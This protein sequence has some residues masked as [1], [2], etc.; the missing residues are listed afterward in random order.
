MWKTEMH[1]LYSRCYDKTPV[2]G[3]LGEK[4]LTWI[5]VQG[6]R[7]VMTGQP[8]HQELDVANHTASS[9]RKHREKNAGVQLAFFPF[10]NSRTPAHMM[11]LPTFSV[12]LP[13]QLTQAQNVFQKHT[14]DLSP[15]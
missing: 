1:L 4:G 11:V 15:R 7:P 14:I 3:F 13:A 5:A 10:V 8:Q 9:V 12:T 2:K 6:N